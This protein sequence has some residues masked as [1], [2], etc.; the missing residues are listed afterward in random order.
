VKKSIFLVLSVIVFAS[1]QTALSEQYY[2]EDHRL[3][4]PPVFCGMEIYDP[5][6]PEAGNKLLEETRKAT[7]EWES[8]LVEYT[9]NT[10]NWKMTY[11]TIPIDN[12]DDLF[13]YDCD[14]TIY[15][16]REPENPDD[17]L[18]L[19]GQT[20]YLIL[21]LAEIKIFYLDVEYEYREEVRNGNKLY[22]SEPVKYTNEL[23]F[24]IA[25]TI[26]HEIGHTLGLGHV[27]ATLSDFEYN[28][29]NKLVSPSIM[30]EEP[31][32]RG[33]L[34]L[35]EITPYDVRAVVSLYGENGFSEEE[36]SEE[37][38]AFLDYLI[39]GILVGIAVIIIY[40]KRKKRHVQ[41]FHNP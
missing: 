10:D 31:K 29:E 24:D 14:V 34:I 11:Q 30:I 21:G 3:I 23:R 8:K 22:F 13:S 26:I 7:S 36:F 33:K 28:S 32:L 40:K 37:Y 15:Y 18:K 16:E 19:A 38:F 5:K 6:L 41:T 9:N 35:Y 17:K 4:R 20:A 39:I 27:P 1:F 12:Q 25:E 2:Y